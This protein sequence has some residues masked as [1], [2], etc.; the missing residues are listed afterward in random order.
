VCVVGG[1]GQAKHNEI[2]PKK[3]Q[4]TQPK[5]YFSLF[6]K[7]SFSYIFLVSLSLGSAA[8]KEEIL[9]VGLSP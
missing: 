6:K 7:S 2:P 8:P 1:K 5:P 9:L 3:E 4:V